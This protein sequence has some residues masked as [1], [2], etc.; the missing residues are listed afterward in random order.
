M[1]STVGEGVGGGVGAAVGVDAGRVVAIVEA[2]QADGMRIAAHGSGAFLMCL[3]TFLQRHQHE[4]P[5]PTS[6]S[7]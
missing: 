5:Q 3:T 4:R 1:G 6:Q 2:P 7:P